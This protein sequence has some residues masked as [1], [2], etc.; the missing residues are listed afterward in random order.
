M[1][2][3]IFAMGIVTGILCLV[4]RFFNYVL[5]QNSLRH[6]LA[7]VLKNDMAVLYAC[8]K[9]FV[10]SHRKLLKIVFI[11][12]AAD[13]ILPILPISMEILDIVEDIMMAIMFCL[14]VII[15][16]PQEGSNQKGFPN[17]VFG[18]TYSVIFMFYW[19]G[20]SVFDVFYVNAPLSEDM[21]I[22]GYGIT[23]ISYVVCIATLGRFMNRDLS[24]LEIVFLGMIMMTTLEFITYYGI[25]YFNNMEWYN[26]AAYE[27][28][29]FGDITSVINRGIYVASQSQ[30]PER[31]PMEI[32]GNIILNG[33]DALTITAVLGY[34]VQKF[35]TK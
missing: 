12:V 25:G 26:L 24:K 2:F 31:T 1:M 9:E 20:A 11:I 3:E 14:L 27:S 19:L 6:N 35:T 8:V 30:I 17:E 18:F 32:W 28:N 29:L 21:W 15:F 13:I 33:T 4:F 23:L 16:V 5:P 7:Q 34:L 10:S 22:Y